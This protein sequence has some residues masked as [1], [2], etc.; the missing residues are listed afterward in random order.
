MIIFD[1]MFI[2]SMRDA[3]QSDKYFLDTMNKYDNIYTAVTFD[4]QPSDVRIPPNLPERLS[5]NLK[6]ESKINIGKKYGVTKGAIEAI[7]Q[8][9]TWKNVQI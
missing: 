6:N 5:Y 4:D 9:K 8:G 2:K 3:K 1:L 7:Y